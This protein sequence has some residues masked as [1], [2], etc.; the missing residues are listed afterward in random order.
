VFLDDDGTAWLAWGNPYLYLARLKPN[1]I[2]LDGPIRKIDLPNY[3]EGPWLYKR[4]GLYYMVY[5]AFAHQGMWEK[6]CYATAP[7]ITGPWTYRGI[8]TGQTKTSFTIH[9]GI[10]EFKGRWYFF[11]HTADLTLNGETGAVGRRSVC[12]EYLDYNPDGTIR[13]IAQTAGGVNGPPPKQ[14]AKP[15]SP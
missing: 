5:A 14:P 4:G 8:L 2:E 3:T 12:V 9:P 6:V 15:I 1:M 7:K 11:Y 13:P 10:A